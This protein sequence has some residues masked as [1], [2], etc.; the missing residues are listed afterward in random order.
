MKTVDPL[1]EDALVVDLG[2]SMKEAL[3]VVVPIFEQAKSSDVSVSPVQRNT[4]KRALELEESEEMFSS[5][6]FK[7]ELDMLAKYRPL[8]IEGIENY[9]KS[10][11]FY[12]F[13]AM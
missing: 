7:T 1:E 12:C 5:K 13:Y 11:L 6:Y 4:K 3:I 8:Q 2:T 10:R 9:I